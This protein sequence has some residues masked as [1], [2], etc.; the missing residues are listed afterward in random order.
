MVKHPRTIHNSR[1]LSISYYK[2][3]LASNPP[4][5]SR[6][7]VVQAPQLRGWAGPRPSFTIPLRNHSQRDQVQSKCPVPRLAIMAVR[8]TSLARKSRLRKV[9]TINS[10][11]AV[12]MP[13]KLVRCRSNLGRGRHN[14]RPHRQCRCNRIWVAW[15]R[16]SLSATNR[17]TLCNW[18]AQPVH[19]RTRAA[20]LVMNLRSF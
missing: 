14:N 20:T 6:V 12:K 7:K 10:F 17:S 3:P 5:T 19:V 2:S 1:T 16:S 8:G 9:S 15:L 18:K 4:N 11:L 13:I